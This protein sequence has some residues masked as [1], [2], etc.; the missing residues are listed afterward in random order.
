MNPLTQS[1]NAT[2]L[3]VLIALTLGCFGLSPQAQ[4]VCREGCDT[5]TAATF[6]GENALVNNGGTSNTAIGANA[7][8]SNT[9]GAANTA[10][11]SAAL[12]GNTTGQSLT[13]IG[14]FALGRNTTGNFNTATGQN[15]LLENT[16]G[17]DNTAIGYNALD[18]NTTGNSN[19]AISRGALGS[20]TSGSNNTAIGF[21]AGNQITGDNN[22]DIGN[23]GAA[24]EAGIIRIGTAGT[25][26][27]TFIAGIR[28]TPLARGVAVG[29]TADG[30]LGVKASSARFKEA[31][32]P[33]E[34]ASE[35]IFALQPV[36]FRYKKAF[37]PQALPQFGLV[38]EQVAKVDPDLV[39]RDAEG[40][41]FTVRYDEVNAML[42]N[43]FLKEHRKVEEQGDQIAEL[44]TTV[45]ELKSAL[46]AQ[47][48]QVQNVSD[49]LKTQVVAPR[50]VADN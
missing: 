20:N 30:Q 6:L 36:T 43:E 48:A 37:D 41:P 21:G 27:A 32:R 42:L 1:K 9:S 45:A 40:K 24:A 11:G 29:I 31:I 19:T 50:V 8:N 46:K 23:A 35:A 34:K 7:L 10:V 17:G 5:S 14:V 33:M 26:T 13:A 44:K 12:L 4:A 49:Q 38:A 16:I 22:I 25:Q 15:A 18:A 3:T 47:A 39:A 28:E 2:I